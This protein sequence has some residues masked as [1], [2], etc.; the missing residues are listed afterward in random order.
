MKKWI[1]EF[2]RDLKYR[3]QA[4]TSPHTKIGREEIV[5][6]CSDILALINILE[7]IEECIE[8]GSLGKLYATCWTLV[9]SDDLPLPKSEPV[10]KCGH[11]LRMHAEGW[12]RGTNS[13]L[14]R[15]CQCNAYLKSV[16]Q[17]A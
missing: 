13:C 1:K 10:C 12:R 4:D 17:G 7:K 3:E 15:T 2:K 16:K 9:V 8:Q 6:G 5:V 11:G 14:Y